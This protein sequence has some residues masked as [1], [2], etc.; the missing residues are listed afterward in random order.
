MYTREV[1]GLY[2]D[3]TRYECYV[4]FCHKVT[5]NWLSLDYKETAAAKYMLGPSSNQPAGS[6]DA[7]EHYRVWE[8]VKKRLHAAQN[9]QDWLAEHL[10][11]TQAEVDAI[12]EE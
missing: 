11:V 10:N 5:R 8:D 4:A 3:V 12:P 9:A 1:S 6:E 7:E 2:A